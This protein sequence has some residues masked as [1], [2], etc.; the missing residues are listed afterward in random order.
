MPKLLDR[1]DPI[2]RLMYWVRERE[3]IRLRKETGESKPW[4]NDPILRR[5]KFTNIRREDDR[6]TRWIAKYWREPYHDH[7]DLWFALCLAR[8]INWPTTLTVIGYP[9]PWR[10][11]W[12]LSK[13]RALRTQGVKVWSG[14]YIVSTNGYDMPKDQYIVQRVLNPLWD[15]RHILRVRLTDTLASY[16]ARLRRCNGFSGFM[17]GQVVADLKYV[18]PLRHC[19]DWYCW[20][21]SGPGSRRGLNRVAGRPIKSTWREAGWLQGVLQVQQQISA[22]IGYQLHAQDVQNCLCEFDKYER[23]RLGQ[24]KPKSKY[25]GV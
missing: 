5:Y 25:E 16:A 22:R 15:E 17:T 10:P 11:L 6:V 18:S 20:A 1:L 12:V 19:D 24:G 8:L 23:A 13:L 4:T 21:V 9:L 2:D 14:A 7:D 3:E